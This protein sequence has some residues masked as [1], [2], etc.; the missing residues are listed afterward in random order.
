MLVVAAAL[1]PVVAYDT[2]TWAPVLTLHPA[3]HIPAAARA[4]D[5]D[6]AAA[7]AAAA[8]AAVNRLAVSQDG[9]VRERVMVGDAVCRS[10]PGEGRGEGEC[11]TFSFP[12]LPFPS[13]I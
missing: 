3:R 11:V 10:C 8:A 12:S 4:A 6:D 9:Q 1:G 7:V 2:R 13:A 5:D